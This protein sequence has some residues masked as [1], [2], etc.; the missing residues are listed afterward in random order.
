[1]RYILIFLKT[2]KLRSC[3]A[4]KSE[5]SLMKKAYASLQCF[6][7]T[8]KIANTRSGSVD[9]A[10]TI[11]PVDSR[12]NCEYIQ[13]QGVNRLWQKGEK[14]PTTVNIALGSLLI[15]NVMPFYYELHLTLT[16]HSLLND[17]SKTWFCMLKYLEFLFEFLHWNLIVIQMKLKLPVQATGVFTYHSSSSP[18]VVASSDL[19]TSFSQSHPSGTVFLFSSDKCHILLKTFLKTLLRRSFQAYFDR[20]ASILVMMVYQPT[21]SP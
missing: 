13:Q 11:L 16:T 6:P 8:V 5:E 14:Q 10:L 20:C 2:N 1:M 4:S 9:C 12:R 18:S 17:I 21:D 15:L 19:F 3:H 7:K